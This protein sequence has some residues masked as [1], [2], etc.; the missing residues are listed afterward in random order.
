MFIGKF[1]REYRRVS[2]GWHRHAR[3]VGEPLEPPQSK[4]WLSANDDEMV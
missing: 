3:S 2:A 1:E 4:L